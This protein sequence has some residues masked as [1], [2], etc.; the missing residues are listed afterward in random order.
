MNIPKKIYDTL[1]FNA[2]HDY[3]ITVE[4]ILSTYNHVGFY[5]GLL[6]FTKDWYPSIRGYKFKDYTCIDLNIPYDDVNKFCSL[7]DESLY[8][9]NRL[10]EYL[11]SRKKKI[12]N[13][14]K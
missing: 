6:Y 7:H 1:K 11:P 2:M 5:K 14:L 3:G 4:Y 13:I 9:I 12:E 10:I 8:P